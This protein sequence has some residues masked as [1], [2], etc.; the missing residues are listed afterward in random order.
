M[1][2]EWAGQEDQAGLRKRL[3][4]EDE[5]LANFAGRHDG[6]HSRAVARRRSRP[7]SASPGRLPSTAGRRCGDGRAQLARQQRREKAE[8]RAPAAKNEALAVLDDAME[9]LR[10]GI[11]ALQDR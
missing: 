7:T 11:D 4:R 9:F 1:F 5:G 6:P 3:C 10:G 2:D 8:Q